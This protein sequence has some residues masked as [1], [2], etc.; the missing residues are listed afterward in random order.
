MG[1]FFKLRRVTIY[2]GGS[3]GGWGSAVSPA[4][5]L[6]GFCLIEFLCL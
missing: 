1:L 6:R 3:E 5:S 4:D 2:G